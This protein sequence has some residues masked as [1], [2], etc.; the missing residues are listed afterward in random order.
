MEGSKNKTSKQETKI[1]VEK[2]ADVIEKILAVDETAGKEKVEGKVEGKA[3][4]KITKKKNSDADHQEESKTTSKKKTSKKAGSKKTEIDQQPTEEKETAGKKK[5]AKKA[6]TEKATAKKIAEKKIT[7]LEENKIAE[8]KA[9][10]KAKVEETAAKTEE[11]AKVEDTAAKAEEKA[12]VEEAAAKVEE[13]AKVEEAAAKKES[14]AKTEEKAAKKESK[15]ET[16]EKAAKKESKAKTEE[17]AAKKE[18]KAKTEEKAAKKEEKAKIEEKA[19]KKEE[20]AKTEE[21][22]AKKESK[23]KT[24]EKAAKKESKVNPEEN[25]V[26]KQEVEVVKE[27]RRSILFVGSECFPFVKTGG[28]AD[29][30]YALPKALLKQ[31]CDVRVILPKYACIPWEYQEKMQYIHHFYMDLCS[32]GTTFYVG[33]MQYEMDGV[34]YYFIDNEGMF[35]YGNPYTDMSNDIPRFCLFSKAV[36]AALP[37]IGFYPEVIHCHDWQTALVPIYLRTLFHDTEVAHRAVSVMTIHNLKFQGVE[38]MGRIRYWSGLPDLVFHEG[39]LKEGIDGNMLKGGITYCNK[40]TTV[41]NTYA[42]EIKTD[43][44]GEN[45]NAHIAY[46][47]MKLCG[48]VNGIDTDMYNPMTDSRIAVN[49]DKENAIAAKKKNKLA[50]QA[51]LGL[52]QNE[53]KFMIAIISRLTDQKGVDLIDTIMNR[54]V[55]DFTQVVILGTGEDRFEHSFRYYEDHFRGRVCSNI[56][57][58]EE[59]AHRIYAAA[60]ALLVPSLFEPCGLTQLIAMRYGTIPVVRETGGLKDTVEPYNEYEQRGNGFSFD[61]Y[62]PEML[63]K[64]VNYAKT[65]YFE[66]RKDWDEMV[67]RDM[68]KD[69]SWERSAAQYRQMYDDLRS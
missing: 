61:A 57:Y 64:M 29:V 50:L 7:E 23:A 11:K 21:K 46:H 5:T 20:K 30:M 66:R 38:N 22:A 37:V 40:L 48:I 47:H 43:F 52:E 42:G 9:E 44:F 51:E 45:L 10:E 36:L 32:D 62:D 19:A 31:N 8:A 63:L 2:N 58:S 54:M 59:R 6:T 41:S 55:D 33:I 67:I 14:K 27:P 39:C 24:E 12:K 34:I 56:M 28:L 3:V 16:E 26:E 25:V 68:E 35:G 18:S 60:D 65:V 49:Y 15:A 13:K 53:D 69:V 17:K 1:T 4:R